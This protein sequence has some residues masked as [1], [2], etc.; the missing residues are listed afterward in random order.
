M[1]VYSW[2]GLN[3][4][5]KSVTGTRDADGPKA[6]RQ[7]L[8]KDSIFITEHRE[9][10]AGGKQWAQ[11]KGGEMP[12]A[13]V[14]DLA[15]HPRDRALVMATHGRTGVQRVALGS[16]ADKVLQHGRAPLVLVHPSPAPISP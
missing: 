9:V 14:R 16:V 11:Y 12:N 2:K 7:A 10:L 5:G 13:A 15:I 8:R 6:L 4:A 1:P 3:T